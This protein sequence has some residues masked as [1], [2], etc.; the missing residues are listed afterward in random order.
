M[1]GALWAIVASAFSSV[2]LTFYFKKKLNL[3]DVRHELII[4]AGIAAGFIFE[5]LV[6]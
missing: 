6:A 2:P 5:K 4:L 1:S 3:L